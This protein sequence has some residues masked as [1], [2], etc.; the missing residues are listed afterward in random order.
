MSSVLIVEDDLDVQALT[1]FRLEAVGHEVH[2]VDDGDQALAAAQ[3]IRPDVVVP[4]WMLPGMSG[5]EICRVLRVVPGLE[6]AVR[7][8]HLLEGAGE[9][10]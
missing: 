8:Q 10:G 5:P 4:D 6:D 9:R 1:V 2:T 7:I 3:R